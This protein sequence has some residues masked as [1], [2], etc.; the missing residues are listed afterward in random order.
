MQFALHW[1]A[2]ETV[3]HWFALGAVLLATLAVGICV[4]ELLHVAPLSFTDAE[5]TVSVLPDTDA[6]STSPIG[7]GVLPNALTGGLVRVEVTDVPTETPDWVLRVAALLPV[8][9][10]LPLVLVAAGVLPD[11]VAAD[12]HLGT[13][14]LVALTGCGLPSPADWAVVWHGSDLA[15]D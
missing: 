12:D 1:F 7:W 3:G 9:L 6:D 10:A 11:P 2:P 5:Y 13:V 15:D 4:H 14:A 8:L